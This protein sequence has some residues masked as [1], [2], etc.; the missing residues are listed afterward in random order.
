M[1]MILASQSPRRSQLL[2]WAAG[3]GIVQGYG[4]GIFLPAGDITREE[5]AVMRW[6]FAKA[7]GDD[8]SIGEN[9]NILSFTDA[10]DVSEWAVS[11]MQWACGAGIITGTGDGSLLAPQGSATRAEVATMLMRYCETVAD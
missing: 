6:R 11:A 5:F 2:R 10:L 3:A 9:T 7:Q 4:D 8:V 1:A